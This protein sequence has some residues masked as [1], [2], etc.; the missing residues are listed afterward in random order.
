[1][2]I[3]APSG[4]ALKLGFEPGQREPRQYKPP[5]AVAAGL[6]AAFE[7]ASGAFE[8]PPEPVSHSALG[9][10]PDAI[11]FGPEWPGIEKH[12]YTLFESISPREL[13]DIGT[14]Y[15]AAL[16]WFGSG[17]TSVMP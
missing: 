10:L 8:P 2:T 13:S 15:V 7:L 11:P 12:G 17:A 9:L 3:D 6:V 4:T 5:A 16:A 1:L 14:A